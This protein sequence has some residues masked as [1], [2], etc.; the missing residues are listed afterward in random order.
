VCFFCNAE[1]EKGLGRRGVRD[2]LSC[3]VESVREKRFF[4]GAEHVEGVWEKR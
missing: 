2:S 4:S 3:S 1:R